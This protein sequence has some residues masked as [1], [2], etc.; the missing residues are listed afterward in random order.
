MTHFQARKYCFSNFQQQENSEEIHQI[1]VLGDENA[2]N[3]CTL[4]VPMAEE[5]PGGDGNMSDDGKG[6]QPDTNAVATTESKPGTTTPNIIAPRT[7]DKKEVNSDDVLPS[8]TNGR[9]FR[10]L[11]ENMRD[12]FN[13]LQKKRDD[14]KA[15]HDKLV[16]EKDACIE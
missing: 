6:D 12:R 7:P 16:S 4:Q 9:K 3:G 5:P 1:P 11:F 13:A 10:A 14:E 15:E 8:S 2:A